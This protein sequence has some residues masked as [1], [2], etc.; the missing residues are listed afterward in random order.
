L[1]FGFFGQNNEM[2]LEIPWGENQKKIIDGTELFIPYILEQ[3]YNGNTPNFSLLL[4]AKGLQNTLVTIL[5][6]NLSKATPNDIEFLNYFQIEIPN[7]IEISA[8][9]SKEINKFYQSINVF[10]FVKENG[11]VMRIN[12]LNIKLNSTPLYIIKN[13]DFVENS[14]LSDESS[15]FY[16]INVQADGIFKIDREW[17]LSNGIISGSF[18]PNHL[19]IYGN[20]AGK[21]SELNS[22][23]KIDDLTKNAIQFVGDVDNE[24]EDGEYFLFFAHG[25]HKWI[26]SANVFTRDLNIYSD[27]STYFIRISA[28]EVPLRIQSFSQNNLTENQTST[29]FNHY[30]IYEQEL[31][32]LV[33]GGQRWY[34]ESFD[35]EL[36]RTFSF[37]IPNLLTTEPIIV[38][39]SFASNANTSGNTI[40]YFVGSTLVSSNPMITTSSD[41]RR[42]N[43]NFNFSHTNSSLPITVTVNRT[44]PSIIS[45]LDKIEINCRRNLI[46]NGSQ[47]RFRDSK[48]VGVGNIT[49]FIVS[50]AQSNY[51]IWDISSRHEPKIVPFNF[52]NGNLEIIQATDALRE[53]V[54]S[55]NSSFFTPTFAGA[56]ASQNLHGL[57]FAD[58]LIVTH[59]DFL[60]QANQL[61]QIHENEGMSTQVVTSTQVYNEFSSGMLD[62]TAIKWFAKMFYDR[63][64]GD[65]TKT[66]KN[67]CL[68][69]DG[70][71]DPKN[72]IAG[73]NYFIPTYQVQYSEDHIAA[74]VTDDYFGMLDDTESM[75]D[76][77]MMDIGVGRMIVSTQEQANQQITKIR[78]YLKKGINTN[79]ISPCGE[80]DQNCSSY[81]D[82]RLKY[83]Q[84]AD[85][86]ENGYFINQDT[87]RQYDSVVKNHPEMNVEKIYLDAF[88][89]VTSAGGE[90]YPDVFNEIT[91]QVQR[92]ALIINYVGHGGEVGVAEERVITIP[93]IQS[94]SNMCNLN[95]FVSATCEFTKFDDPERV[96]AGEWVFLNPEGGAIALMT[97]TRSV[98]FGVNTLTG[99]RFYANVFERDTDNRPKTFGEIMR[100]TK[101]QAGSNSNKRSFNLIGDPALRINLP[102]LEIV[103]DS[104]NGFSPNLYIDTLKALSKVR[105]KG[106]IVDYNNNIQ[107]NFTGQIV[108][109]IY[110]KKKKTTTL[111]QNDDSPVIEFY[112]QKNVLYKGK[113]SVTNGI[114]DFSFVVPKDINYSY[115]FGKI[116]LYSNSETQDAGSSEERMYVGGIN[117]NGL[118]DVKGPEINLFLN[119][120]NFVNGGF[121][122][123]K[124]LLVVKLFDDNGINTVGN[125]I[126]HDLTA[127][128]DE[129]SANPIVLN[130]Y[131]VS[132][133]DTY[134][135]GSLRY[136]LSNLSP[137]R[138]NLKFKAWDVNNNSSEASIDFEVQLSSK[139]ELKHVLNY[140]NPFTTHTEFMFE[141]NQ[142]C[143]PLEVQI[144]VF[145]ISGK[146]VKTINELVYNQCYYSGGIPWDGRDDYGDQLAKGVYIYN[147][148]ATNS[149]RETVNKIEKLVLLK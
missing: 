5:S 63:A 67:L 47:F 114:F 49:K 84:I 137:G 136:N 71:Y 125:G 46:F 20:A 13:K 66:P 2:T 124:P 25:P 38:S 32:S 149:R 61:A 42:M 34:G 127:I 143:D 36:S 117:P 82:W 75:G 147:L 26:N 16:K 81:G 90:R 22:E 9:N 139:F 129:E 97:T 89:Q 19:N 21:L 69:G 18:N 105:M 91:N 145:T 4:K 12:F 70:T 10:P 7:Q 23:P 128:I 95:L 48:S 43:F 99:R 55:N 112:T 123:E 51:F 53:F 85:D 134:Q 45:Y 76:S 79:V 15:S 40:N 122:D 96:S 135:S 98:Y 131:Y 103:I 102:E 80:G 1:S 126:G 39:S 144:Q 37:S 50:N 35:T 27:V 3:S 107:N 6:K 57:D 120:E 60:S 92:G 86:E 8:S 11:Q 116:S 132:D 31:K 133:L 64:S 87:E 109:T 56:V 113:A 119:N 138:H 104:I 78:Q 88:Q 142:L 111:G 52:V 108:P 30:D 110:D 83:V 62:P 65:L 14:I 101:N 44:S 28:S 74:L 73:N 93:Q 148:S 17:L 54:C 24:L 140:P 130:N 118:E 100:L 58:Y 115:G 72:R 68:F 33:G 77:D 41:Y 29:S 59:P 94:W 106:H 146:L 121:T 141:H